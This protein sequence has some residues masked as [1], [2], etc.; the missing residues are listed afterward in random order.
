MDRSLRCARN[1]LHTHL[2]ASFA[3]N[4]AL[5]LVWYG[6]V[7]PHPEVVTANGVWCRLLSA[8][9]HY[10]LLASY[11]WMLCEGLYLHTLLVA[12]FVSESKLVKGLAALGWG[13]PLLPAVTY[14]ALRA[15]D[16]DPDESGQ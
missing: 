13:V 8:V 5:W 2:F 12:A 1:T 16:A 3:A 7:I 4:N 9:L 11:T 6:A 14:S 10:C 15:A